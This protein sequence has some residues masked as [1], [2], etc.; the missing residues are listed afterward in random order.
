MPAK[1]PKVTTTDGV[2]NAYVKRLLTNIMNRDLF[3]VLT[4]GPR[5]MKKA[6]GGLKPAQIVNHLA[7]AELAMAFRFRMA[8]AQS[9]TPLQAWDEN[10]WAEH[11]GYEKADAKAKMESYAVLR[12]DH[13]ALL[14]S[15]DKDQLERYGMHEERGKETVLRM[16]Q[17]LAGHDVNHIKRIGEIRKT[18]T[19]RAK[20]S[21]GK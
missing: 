19:G 13:V 14:K 17:L 6:L 4:E 9:G 1:L 15:L 18:L 2:E 10:L 5:L 12:R 16:A 20:R 21:A 7:D 11:L 3:E 8:L